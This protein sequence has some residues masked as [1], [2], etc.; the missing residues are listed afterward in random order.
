MAHGVENVRL[1]VTNTLDGWTS[2]FGSYATDTSTPYLLRIAGISRRRMVL[3]I[4]DVMSDA[5]ARA[6]EGAASLRLTQW[7]T[8]GAITFLIGYT[9][10]VVKT[11]QNIKVDQSVP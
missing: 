4:W 11:S 3:V 2:K 8:S 5:M 1:G 7:G 10:F 9:N 6:T